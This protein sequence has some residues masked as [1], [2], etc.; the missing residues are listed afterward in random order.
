MA[1]YIHRKI[2]HVKMLAM[3]GIRQKE[4]KVWT[5]IIFRQ[6]ASL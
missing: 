2:I 4:M 5:Q 6:R 1:G 3:L